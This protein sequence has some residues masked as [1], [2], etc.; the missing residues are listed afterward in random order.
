MRTTIDFPDDLHR[1]TVAIARDRH[2]TLS[3]T[4]SDLLRS[5][6]AAGQGEMAVE[7]DAET[8]L[9]LVRLGRRVT[10]SDV[11]DAQDAG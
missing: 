3:R 9:P 1:A 10:A 5:A 4:V 11:A 6:L 2:Q 7:T 8:G